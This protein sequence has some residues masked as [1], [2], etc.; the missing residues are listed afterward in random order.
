MGLFK[1]TAHGGIASP[2]KKCRRSA[3]SVSSAPRRHS[4]CWCPR[5]ESNRHDR[6]VEGFSCHFGFRRQRPGGRCSWSGARLHPG[7][8][9][10]GAR[11]LLSTPSVE[12]V[13]TS[14]SAWLGVGS[15]SA[16][17]RTLVRIGHRPGRSPNLTGF[18]SGVSTG[19]LKLPQVPCVYRFHHSGMPTTAK[20]CRLL[21]QREYHPH[22]RAPARHRPDRAGRFSIAF[23]RRGRFLFHRS[24]A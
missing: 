10:V 17:C 13:E 21:S 16:R 18:I 19:G 23:P 8:A 1:Y 20:R 5:P 24:L 3:A 9:T 2:R 12:S 7:P 6:E 22:R 14:S 4:S 11:R 15:A